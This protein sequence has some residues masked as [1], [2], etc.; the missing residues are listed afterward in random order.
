MRQPTSCRS[1]SST[2]KRVH[3]RVGRPAHGAV[4]AEHRDADAPG[5]AKSG[6]SIM[7][8]CLSPRSPCCGPKAA[9]SR[10]SPQRRERVERVRRGRASPTPD[11]RPGR[12]AFPPAGA[13]ARDPRAGDR[14]RTSCVG[15]PR[16]RPQ[17]SGRA[18]ARTPRPGDGSR[19]CCTSDGG[20]PSTSSRPF[21]A[22]TTT[23]KPIAERRRRHMSIERS[24]RARRA[25]SS[26][27]RIVLART[28]D[29]RL[30]A[31]R[32]RAGRPRGRRVNAYAAH[33]RDGEKL[34]STYPAV[35]V[36]AATNA[37]KHVCFQSSPRRDA[38]AAAGCGCRRAHP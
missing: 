30:E 4:E 28:S 26:G 38:R 18:E 31:A 36:R 3:H 13:G 2:S 17:R 11:G 20:A 33:S 10:T 5:R 14:F 35:P 23:D 8:S 24:A 37:S 32:R 27:D 12:R 15:D 6:D 19:A 29:P 1:T 9:V 7:L 21:V 16:S 25:T 22:S 34:S